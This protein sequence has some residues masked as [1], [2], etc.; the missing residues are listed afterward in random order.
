MADNLTTPISS[1]LFRHYENILYSPDDV[2]LKDWTAED[3]NETDIFLASL[4]DTDKA[5]FYELMGLINA[6]NEAGVFDAD[7]I[8]N[9]MCNYEIE[10]K[11]YHAGLE[12]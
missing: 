5:L 10:R 6:L 4:S 1:L 11:K 12:V 3:E 8:Y 9:V 2:N 7:L